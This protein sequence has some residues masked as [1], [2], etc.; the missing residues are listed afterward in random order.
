MLKESLHC[1][2]TLHAV[3]LAANF[4]KLSLVNHLFIR[5]YVYVEVDCGLIFH[6]ICHKCKFISGIT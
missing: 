5:S 4:T 6:E 3:I 2:Q 1:N